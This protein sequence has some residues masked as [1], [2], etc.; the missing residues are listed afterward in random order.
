MNYK[1]NS[2]FYFGLEICP[3]LLLQHNSREGKDKRRLKLVTQISVL[4]L[5]DSVLLFTDKLKLDEVD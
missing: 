2:T 5:L 1:L 3:L 4:E